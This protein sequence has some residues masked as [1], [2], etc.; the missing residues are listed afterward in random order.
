MF[1]RFVRRSLVVMVLS[2]CGGDLSGRSG[3]S[4]T[5][6]GPAADSGRVPQ[7]SCHVP[8]TATRPDA[9]DA[10]ETEVD[11][12]VRPDPQE[13]YRYPGCDDAGPPSHCPRFPNFNCAINA[14]TARHNECLEGCD[15]TVAP[16]LRSCTP[17]TCPHRVVNASRAQAWL[18]EVD[19]EIHRYCDGSTCSF[20]Y[21]CGIPYSSTLASCISGRCVAVRGDG[22]S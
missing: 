21:S 22:G 15:C 10:G 17:F 18:D 4:G 14:I 2:G 11:G 7:S 5:E 20:I 6:G 16:E 13:S 3:D 1:E 8:F 9:G 19:A 12:G